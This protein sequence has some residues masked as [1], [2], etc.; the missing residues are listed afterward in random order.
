M[1]CS[2]ITSYKLWHIGLGIPNA[3]H[4]YTPSKTITIIS[5][6]KY[7]YS[8]HYIK[9]K[10]IYVNDLYKLQVLAF[11]HTVINE[12]LPKHVYNILYTNISEIHQYDTRDKKSDIYIT[13][14]LLHSFP[15]AVSRNRRKRVSL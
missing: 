2:H 5:L 4:V 8:F 9:I 1:Q 10:I 13:S 7:I 15:E 11:Y 14:Y 6:S 12:Q 3:S